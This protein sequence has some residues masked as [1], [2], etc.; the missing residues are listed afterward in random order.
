MKKLIFTLILTSA[1]FIYAAGQ[2]GTLEVGMKAPEWKFPDAGGKDFTM[3]SWPGKVLQ[4]NYVDPDE[5]DLTMC[6]M[7]LLIKQQILT[8]V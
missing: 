1:A 2:S 6:S 4:I 8:N 5:S 7:T 3:D